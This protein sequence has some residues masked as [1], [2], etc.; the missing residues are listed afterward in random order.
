[1]LTLRYGLTSFND[2]DTLSIDFDPATLGFNQLL[3]QRHPAQ[4]VPAASLHGRLLPVRPLAPSTPPTACG[5]RGAPTRTAS[6]LLGRAHLQGSAATSA[7]IGIDTQSF[8]GGAGRLQLRPSLHL[9]QPDDRGQRQRLCHASLLLGYPSGDPG[10]LSRLGMSTPLNAFALLRRL[11]AGRLPREPKFT[12]NSGLR[13]EHEDGLRREERQLH[14]GLRPHPEPR[15]RAGRGRGQPGQPAVRGGLVYAG[16]E[17]R[18]RLPGRPA[19]GEVLAAPRHG[20]LVRSQDGGARRLRHLLGAVELSGR[21]LA[22]TTATSASPRHRSSS[23][24]SSSPTV[25]STNPFPNGAL[26]P[27]GNSLRRA[28][29]ASAARS[30]SSTRTRRRPMC[31]STRSTSTASC[32]ATWRLASNTPAPPAVDL[33]FGGSND[34]ILNINQLDPEVPVA[35]H[36]A[37]RAGAQPVL[38]SARRAGQE[39]DQPDD[40]SAASCCGRS[41]SSTTS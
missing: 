30:S 18:Q 31:T 2:T 15:R 7:R 12:L 8:S 14:R 19:G 38:R 22:P 9:V 3:H 28:R 20:L 1:M 5:T 26:Q 4:E 34:G 32:P 16:A 36:R 17:R 13:L 25:T 35:R 21:Q 29:P 37:A 39:R 40:C 24:T 41:R 10:N 6:K 33:G 23:R 27:V 11:S